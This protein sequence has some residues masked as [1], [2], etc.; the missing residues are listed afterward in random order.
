MT[1]GKELGAETKRQMIEIISRYPV[2]GIVLGCMRLPI[3]FNDKTVEGLNIVNTL[4]R[5]IED[6]LT[7]ATQKEYR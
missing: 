6:I 1:N 2:D 4:E 3:F 5:H 7:F